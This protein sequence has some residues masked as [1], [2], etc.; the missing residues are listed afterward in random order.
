MMRRPTKKAPRR[1]AGLSCLT[2]ALAAIFCLIP[3]GMIAGSRAGFA[4]MR[5]WN[6]DLIAFAGRNASEEVAIVFIE[7]KTGQSALSARERAVKKA[8]EAKQVSW[9]VINPDVEV[10]ARV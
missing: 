7:V 9:R 4:F 10:M 6:R 8:V 3:S 1:S 5:Y 2:G